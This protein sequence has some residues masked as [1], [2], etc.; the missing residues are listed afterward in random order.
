VAGTR[1][2]RPLRWMGKNVKTEVKRRCCGGGLK[3][4]LYLWPLYLALLRLERHGAWSISTH[5]VYIKQMFAFAWP[6]RLFVGLGCRK[7]DGLLFY[8]VGHR[9]A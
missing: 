4:A 6:S 5:R 8:V 2:E 9:R 3:E 7:S 1:E